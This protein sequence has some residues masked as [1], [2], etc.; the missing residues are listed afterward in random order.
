MAGFSSFGL[1][2]LLI[3]LAIALV[4]FGPKKIPDLASAI[5][6]AIRNFKEAR[7]ANAQIDAKEASETNDQE[8]L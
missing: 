7:K 4:I 2:E 1:P 8:N 6:K 5:G 3:I